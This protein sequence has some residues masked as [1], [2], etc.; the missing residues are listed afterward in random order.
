GQRFFGFG[1]GE[2]VRMVVELEDQQEALGVAAVFGF[3]ALF[4]FEDARAGLLQRGPDLL[5]KFVGFRLGFG[6]VADEFLAVFDELFGGGVFGFGEDG[7]LWSGVFG[8][9]FFLGFFFRRFACGFWSF[10]AC[11]A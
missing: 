2:V 11:G 6:L 1:R 4:E 9:R 8:Q 3:V 10:S 7:Q 5:F